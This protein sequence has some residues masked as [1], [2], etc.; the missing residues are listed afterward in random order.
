MTD[1]GG[2][3]TRRAPLLHAVR[4]SHNSQQSSVGQQERT[5]T[6]RAVLRLV[7]TC[8][9]AGDPAYAS[10]AGELNHGARVGADS[11]C[12]CVVMRKALRLCFSRSFAALK[13][14]VPTSVPGA[15]GVRAGVVVCRKRR[16]L[17]TRLKLVRKLQEARAGSVT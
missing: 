17:A 12:T 15:A 7:Q 2:F 1:R 11:N 6:V 8:R 16:E 14:R 10:A 4:E 13:Y 9:G 5:N 3:L